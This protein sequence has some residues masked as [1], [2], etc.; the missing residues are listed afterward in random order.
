MAATLVLEG[1]SI[2]SWPG[3]QDEEG[4]DEERRMGCDDAMHLQRL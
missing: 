3:A 1:E 2:Y 4:G